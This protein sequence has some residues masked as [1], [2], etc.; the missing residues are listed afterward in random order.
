MPPRQPRLTYVL[1]VSLLGSLLCATA[2]QRGEIRETAEG[3]TIEQL[4]E[5]YSPESIEI[6]QFTKP[7]SFDDDAIPDGI[8]VSLRPKDCGGDTV[9][10][11]GEFMFEL[12]AYRSASGQRRGQLLQSW[13]QPVVD[14]DDQKQFW[15]HVTTT[16]EFQ[17]SWEGSPIPPQRKYILAVSFQAPGGKRLFDEYEFEF[18]VHRSEIL[19]ALSESGS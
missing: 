14:L 3:P 2:C 18:R 5:F 15:D 6:L 19:K 10:A 16:Y 4:V 8:G 12:Y 11:Y 17:L 7:K 13:S 1:T 9:K